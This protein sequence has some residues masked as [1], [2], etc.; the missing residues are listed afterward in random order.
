MGRFITVFI[1]ST[2]VFG[3]GWAKKPSVERV[4][5][6]NW[7]VG[8]NDPK[9]ELMLYGKN[10]SGLKPIITYPGV[11]VKSMFSGENPNY[12]FIDLQISSDAKPGILNI[13]FKAD[14]GQVDSYQYELK[15]RLKNPEEYVGFEV[16]PL[17]INNLFPKDI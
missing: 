15:E 6:P 5:P 8:M 17:K 9:L 12:L 7:W 3:I 10:I 11:V 1:I 14:N 4:D 16:Y 13:A 2:F